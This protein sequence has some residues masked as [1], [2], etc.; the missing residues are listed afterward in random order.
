MRNISQEA[1]RRFLIGISRKR[2][3]PGAS[4]E[5]VFRYTYLRTN[6]TRDIYERIVKIAFTTLARNVRGLGENPNRDKIHAESQ[7]FLVGSLK[8]IDASSQDEYDEWHRETMAGLIKIF[9]K[10]G[11]AFTIGQAQKWINMSIKHLAIY[12]SELTDRYYHFA[13][14]PIDSYIISALK[15]KIDCTFGQDPKRY[16]SWNNID[17][18]GSY[19]KFQR[20]FRE[21][22]GEAPL[23]AEFRL[24]MK[25]RGL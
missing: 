5:D 24:W 19:I 13:H 3:D 6:G 15:D 20:D 8:S 18:Y 9:K 21:Y 10:F 12:S 11:Q 14:I 17:D 23:D 25:E 4:Y 16:I 22:C 7:S 2:F 1:K